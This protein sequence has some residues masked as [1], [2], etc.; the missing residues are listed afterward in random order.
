MVFP[1]VAFAHDAKLE[2]LKNELKQKL[3]TLLELKIAVADSEIQTLSPL[4]SVGSE[5]AQDELVTTQ[6]TNTT[7]TTNNTFNVSPT[8]FSTSLDQIFAQTPTR[9]TA[10]FSGTN[11]VEENIFS[12]SFSRAEVTEDRIE[13]TTNIQATSARVRAAVALVKND[14]QYF[15]GTMTSFEQFKSFALPAGI[16]APF[17]LDM[18]Y[19]G[20]LLDSVNISAEVE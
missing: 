11:T 18:R 8:S 6:S 2:R 10:T 20:E 3:Y 17:T 9:S 13:V 15:L 4:I 12:A 19:R 14:D 16:A 5:T 1:F 7:V